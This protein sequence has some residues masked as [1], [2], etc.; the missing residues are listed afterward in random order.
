MNTFMTN[1]V[2]T[3]MNIKEMTKKY[4]S[5]GNQ[6]TKIPY[7]KTQEFYVKKRIKKLIINF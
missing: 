2:F 7:S 4:L 6:I 3:R 5:E 1:K